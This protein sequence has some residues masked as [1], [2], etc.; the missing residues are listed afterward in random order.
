MKLQWNDTILDTDNAR[1]NKDGSFTWD[2]PTTQLTYF[3]DTGTMLSMDNHMKPDVVLPII[4]RRKQ[5]EL[6]T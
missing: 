3:P 2:Y 1:A 4:Y 6:P 5:N